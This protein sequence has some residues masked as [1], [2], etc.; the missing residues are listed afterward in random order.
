MSC[1][2]RVALSLAGLGAL[3]VAC[4]APTLPLPPPAIPIVE[5]AG[6]AGKVMLSSID[7]VEPGAFVVTINDDPNVPDNEAVG[8]ARA[9]ENGSWNATIAAFSGDVVEIRQEFGAATSPSTVVQIP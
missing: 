3:L 2:L 4:E 5:S 8:G 9:D 6:V 1:V 7:G